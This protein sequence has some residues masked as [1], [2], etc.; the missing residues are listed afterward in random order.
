[1]EAVGRLEL[2]FNWTATGPTRSMRARKPIAL[3]LSWTTTTKSPTERSALPRKREQTP[4]PQAVLR[5][6]YAQQPRRGISD[7]SFG[8]DSPGDGTGGPA[9][10]QENARQCREGHPQKLRILRQGGTSRAG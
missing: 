4:L 5:V 6:N 9:E 8:T 2:K 3:F 7:E 10:Y 1:M